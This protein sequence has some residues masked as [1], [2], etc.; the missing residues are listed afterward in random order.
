MANRLALVVE[1]DRGL[2][3]IYD[4]ILSELSY[5]VLEAQD[6]EIALELLE[7]HTPDILFLDILL[8]RVSGSVILDYIRQTPRLQNMQ[9]IIV[10][11][12]K[13]FNLEIYGLDN[14]Q[15]LLKPIRPSQIR[16]LANSVAR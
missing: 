11:S 16:A 14:A 1:D 12:S 3:A 8:P 4:R 7:K 2:M 5:D 6:G 15:F 9:I 13:Q 10:T